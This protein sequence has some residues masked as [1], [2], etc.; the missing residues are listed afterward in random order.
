MNFVHH[1]LGQRQ[2]GEIVEITLSGNAANVRLMDIPNF[3]AY[4][5]GRKHRYTGGLAKKSPFHL[6]I[7][8]TGRWHVAVDMQGLRGQ[9]RSSA[10]ILPKPLPELHQ[11]SRASIPSM[12]HS[13]RKDEDTE[14]DVFI[15]YASE[16]KTEFVHPLANELR[17]AGLRVW[18]DEFEMGIGDSLRGK[19]DH[20][21]AHSR[22]SVVVLSRSFVKKGWPSYELDGIVTRSVSG[23]SDKT[24]LPIWH[25]ITKQE[26][27]NYSPSLAGKVAW[28]TANYTIA[29]IASEIVDVVRGT[30]R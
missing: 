30:A 10:R 2:R 29:E 5:G 15:S 6:T 13:F 4:K 7:P 14:Y 17:N 25:D 8:S 12:I 11:P 18:Y 16:D 23:D 22:F 20:G 28:S 9:V 24:L 27:M 19:I 21:I 1:D 3:N 26:V